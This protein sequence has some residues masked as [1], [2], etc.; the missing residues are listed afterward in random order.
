MQRIQCR[1]WLNYSIRIQSHSLF[2]P[3]VYSRTTPLLAD[4]SKIKSIAKCGSPSCLFTRQLVCLT[5]AHVRCCLRN[6]KRITKFIEMKAAEKKILTV[7]KLP[8]FDLYPKVKNILTFSRP[9]I[10]S[11]LPSPRQLSLLKPV[12]TDIPPEAPNYHFLSASSLDYPSSLLS[13][14]LTI[15]QTNSTTFSEIAKFRLIL[16][17]KCVQRLSDF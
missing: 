11:I 7:H 17:Y 13:T 1:E 15:K 8:A 5:K 14:D 12:L 10:I 6:V 4:P 3:L 16:L 9:T 2:G